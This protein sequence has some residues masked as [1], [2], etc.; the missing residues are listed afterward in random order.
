MGLEFAFALDL[1][2]CFRLVGAMGLLQ[3]SMKLNVAYRCK[4]SYKPV[5]NKLQN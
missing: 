4:S 2:L 1:K 3:R 5:I